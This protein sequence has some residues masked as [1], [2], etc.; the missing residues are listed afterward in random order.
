MINLRVFHHYVF[1]GRVE[2]EG[3]GEFKAEDIICEKVILPIQG[4]RSSL[5]GL[6]GDEHG[7]SLENKQILHTITRI[8]ACML[9]AVESL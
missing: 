9:E 4:S 1:R 7:V 2:T 6:E 3:E 8:L 5:G